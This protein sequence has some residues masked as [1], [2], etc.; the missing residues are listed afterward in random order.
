MYSVN[1]IFLHIKLIWSA[2]CPN[3]FYTIWDNLSSKSSSITSITLLFSSC[4]PLASGWHNC[5]HVSQIKKKNS[6]RLSKCLSPLSRLQSSDYEPRR[7]L[8]V[9]RAFWRLLCLCWNQ[10]NFSWPLKTG[11]IEESTKFYIQ[12]KVIVKG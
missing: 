9:R 1:L 2:V 8:K 6:L 3:L 10:K 4:F 5:H 7:L 12:L 11:K